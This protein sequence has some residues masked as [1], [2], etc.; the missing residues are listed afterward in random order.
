MHRKTLPR[1]RAACDTLKVEKNH[2]L[3]ASN[4]AFSFRLP[5]RYAWCP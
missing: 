5:G 4:P 1:I 3:S 2:E